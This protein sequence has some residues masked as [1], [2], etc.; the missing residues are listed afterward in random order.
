[1]HGVQYTNHVPRTLELLKQEV[2][3]KSPYPNSGKRLEISSFS[4]LKP[5]KINSNPPINI[6]LELSTNRVI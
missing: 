1:M 3:H 6:L 4:Y 2:R 5:A